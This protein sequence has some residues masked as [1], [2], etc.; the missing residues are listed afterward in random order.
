MSEQAKKEE[1]TAP[2]K[3]AK[4]RTFLVNFRYEYP[5]F[6][7]LPMP[8]GVCFYGFHTVKTTRKDGKFPTEKQLLALAT[9]Q[10]V[11]ELGLTIESISEVPQNW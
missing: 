10:K 2:A 9:Q 7:G 5:P 1:K 3:H 8:S 4:P 11:P 6:G